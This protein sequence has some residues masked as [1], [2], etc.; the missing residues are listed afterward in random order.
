MPCRNSA[1][2]PEL[3]IDEQDI[4][5]A[6]ESSAVPNAVKIEFA[7][8]EMAAVNPPLPETLDIIVA[9][10]LWNPPM[11]DEYSATMAAPIDAGIRLSSASLMKL[12]IMSH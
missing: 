11:I 3:R 12:S 8:F 5:C 7:K 9:K 2:A 1:I 4:P 10:M 6:V